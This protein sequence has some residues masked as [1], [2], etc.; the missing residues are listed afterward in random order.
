MCTC[1][2]DLLTAIHNTMSAEWPVGTVTRFWER[3]PPP[4]EIASGMEEWFRKLGRDDFEIPVEYVLGVVEGLDAF[5]AREGLDPGRFFRTIRFRCGGGSPVPASRILPWLKPILA[6]VSEGTGDRIVVVKVL[7]EICGRFIPGSFRRILSIR[8]TEGWC[9]VLVA[10]STVDPGLPTR[11]SGCLGLHEALVRKAPLA[12]GLPE[13]EEVEFVATRMPPGRFVEPDRIGT[14]DGALIVDGIERGRVVGFHDFLE[15]LGVDPV[16]S[17]LS[18]TRVV[19]VSEDVESGGRVVLRSGHAYGAPVDLERIR[20]ASFAPVDDHPL[21]RLVD[22]LSAHTGWNDPGTSRRNDELMVNAGRTTLFTYHS[23]DES[24]AVDGRHFV[25]S[26]PAKI[27]RKVLKAYVH[28]GR[29]LFEFRE[30]KR[31]EEITMNP[32]N[33]GFEVRL[34]RLE[35]NMRN[36]VPQVGIRF[37]RKGVFSFVPTSAIDFRES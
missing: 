15:R 32:K 21:A 10:F 28:E 37:E 29:T 4:V 36:T 2:C 5:I 31:D 22:D 26:V 11:W 27:L 3:H 23:K 16:A 34:R 6:E 20:F 30:F 14:R 9:E 7:D 18:D 12:F 19:V 35:M 8:R 33:S 24:I 25:R 13:F 17:G 1:S